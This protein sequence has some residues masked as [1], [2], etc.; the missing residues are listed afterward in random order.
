MAKR[1]KK[2]LESSKNVDPVARYTFEEAVDLVL[3]SA[4]ANFN[5]SVD[6]AVNLGVDPRKADQMVRGSVVLPHGTGREIRIL[7][8]A[9]GEK[10]KEAEE[11]GAD[12]V[13]AEDMVEK[14][15]KGW[16]EFDKAVATPDMMSAV[17][18]LGRILGPR[19]LMPNAKVGT[20]TFEI[21]KAVEELKAGKIE[22]R[23]EKTGVIHS[24]LGKVSFGPEKILENLRVFLDALVRHKPASSKGA[25]FRGIALS[26]TMGPGVKVDPAQ[27]RMFL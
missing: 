17:G 27:M 18:K 10:Q 14:I 12:Y 20:V 8:F 9:K 13:G 4:Y 11:A 1:S 2:Y 25:Y 26:S 19:G 22:F 7:A 3:R 15:E 21:G 5:E 16:L 6:V 24:V 23:V